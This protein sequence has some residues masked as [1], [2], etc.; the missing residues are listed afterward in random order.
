MQILFTAQQ[1][2]YI[3]FLVNIKDLNIFTMFTLLKY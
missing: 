2:K 3:Y 1:M